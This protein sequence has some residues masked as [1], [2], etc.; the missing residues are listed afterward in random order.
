L[1][2]NFSFD[3]PATVTTENKGHTSVRQDKYHWILGKR[4]YILPI[5][6]GEFPMNTFLKLAL[7]CVICI[8]VISGLVLLVEGMQ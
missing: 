5:L 6:V 3:K 8:G 2:T 7:A 1:S 4:M